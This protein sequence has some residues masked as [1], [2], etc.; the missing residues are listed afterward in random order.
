[1]HGGLN[2]EP[3]RVAHGRRKGALPDATPPRHAARVDPPPQGEGEQHLTPR[4][5][6]A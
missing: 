6:D 1:M 4:G 2:V 3:R 5:R